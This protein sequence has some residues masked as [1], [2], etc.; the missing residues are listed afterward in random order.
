MEAKYTGAR[1]QVIHFVYQ[2][3][4][5]RAFFIQDP[6][7]VHDH[8]VRVGKLLGKNS[9]CKHIINLLFGFSHPILSQSLLGLRFNN[10]IGLSAGFDKNA[11][12]LDIMPSVGFGF[13]EVGSITGKPCEGN[14][15][16]RLWRLKKTKSLL[17][18]YGLKNDGA[19]VISKRLMNKKFR[20]PVGISIAK[21]NNEETCDAATGVKD[22]LTAY[23]AFKNI[24]DYYTINISCP[25]TF[26]GQP[27]TNPKL[28]NVLL[29]EMDSLPK[30]K[31]IFIKLS[32]D[33]SESEV[34]A[35][36]RIADQYDID[37]FVIS[38]LTKNRQN[39]AIKDTIE[40]P[41]GGMSGKAVQNLADE[42]ISYVYKKTR[43]RY[44][45]IGCGGVFTAEDA[46]KKIKLGSS[47]IQMITGMIFEGPQVISEINRGLVQLLKKDGYT[48]IS[49]AIGAAHKA[50]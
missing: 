7:K 38:N 4:L 26:G 39:P 24:G 16:P 44:V 34:D 18:Y 12:L 47:L 45:I 31:P 5:K 33:L 29:S 11:E 25:N 42:M 48:N 2:K 32:P 19:A 8:M 43:G 10:P 14:P 28:L 49:Q 20:F 41:Q 15:K 9:I 22:Y 27:F 17:V 40:V 3:V 50:K 21:T 30:T 13:E 35:I 37:G 23:K 6:E 36:L 1:N 46:Y